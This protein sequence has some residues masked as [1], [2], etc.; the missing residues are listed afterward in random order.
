MKNLGKLLV[1]LLLLAGA[2]T[3]YYFY[4]QYT[5]AQ[6][7][8]MKLSKN[9]QASAQAELQDVITN[10]GKLIALPKGEA[11][12]LATV[13]DKSKLG[14]QPFFAKAKNGDKVLVYVKERRI[15]LYRPSSNQLI[16]VGTITVNQ[17]A[18]TTGTPSPTEQ[19]TPAQ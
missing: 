18:G 15:Y 8:V 11:P 3:S 9:P 6:E 13:T 7:Q 12:T 17:E 1:A 14:T 19:V 5:V 2:G 10:V 16:E 4:N